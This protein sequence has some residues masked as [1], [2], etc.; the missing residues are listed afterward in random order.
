MTVFEDIKW[1]P[2]K[3]VS[4]Y[5]A[6][7]SSV[8]EGLNLARLRDFHKIELHVDSQVVVTSILDSNGGIV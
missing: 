4:A 1:Q 2:L 3:V 6:E 7:L 8:F 5:V